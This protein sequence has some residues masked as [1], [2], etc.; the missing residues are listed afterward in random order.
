MSEITN[1]HLLSRLRTQ[2]GE[3]I[4]NESTPHELATIVL[5]KD[6][7]TEVIQWLYNDPEFKFQFL[8]DVCGIHFPDAKGAELGVVYHLHSLTNNLRLRIKCFMPAKNPSIASI[9]EIFPA[10]NW[11]E[12]ETFDFFGIVFEGHPNLKRILNVD[13]M[14]YFPMRK[15][16][17]LEDGTRTDK[18]DQY[19][20][21]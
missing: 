13:E 19:F 1:E 3:F 20:G 4:Y 10:A 5:H 18:E 12:R 8:T 15:E 11:Q 14:D 6:K 2:F 21:R 17:P 7:I 9:S 16:F